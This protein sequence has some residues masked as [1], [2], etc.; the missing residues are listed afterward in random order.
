MSYHGGGRYQYGGDDRGGREYPDRGR[1][2]ERGEYRGTYDRSR[3]RD[4][5]AFMYL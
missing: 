3:S 4:E 2:R 5:G 1:D